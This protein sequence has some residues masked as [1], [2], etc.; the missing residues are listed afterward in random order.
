V[1]IADAGAALDHALS[2]PAGVY[3]VC[4]DGGAISNDR[5]KATTAW[6]PGAGRPIER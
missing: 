2:A 6:C 3:N 4:D 5:F 1:H